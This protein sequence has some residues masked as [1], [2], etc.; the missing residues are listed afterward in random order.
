MYKR[1]PVW[2]WYCNDD[3]PNERIEEPFEIE[4]KKLK[5]PGTE[6]IAPG[7]V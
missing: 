3:F 6:L 2:F 7:L 1:G 4:N 5:N